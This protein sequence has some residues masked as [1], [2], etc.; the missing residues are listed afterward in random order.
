MHLLLPPSLAHTHAAL[1]TD[2]QSLVAQHPYIATIAAVGVTAIVIRTA[3]RHRH[4][5]ASSK[6]AVASDCDVVIVG[7]GV[8]G[9][10]LATALARQ[11]RRVTVIERSMAEPDRIVGELMQPGGVKALRTLGLSER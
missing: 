5:T 1:L 6:H 4:T 9:A 2:F 3:R 10:A 7:C 11:G 8:G